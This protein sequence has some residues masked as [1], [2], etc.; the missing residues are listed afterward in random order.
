MIINCLVVD[1]EKLSRDYLSEL[2]R[3]VPY[4]NL[5]A[6][7]E[8]PNDVYLALKKHDIKLVFADIQMPEL[9]GTQLLKS[10]TDPP[11]FIYVTGSTSFAVESYEL[12]ALDYL[13]KPFSFERFLKSADKALDKLMLREGK[14]NP[15]NFITVKDR[16][17]T[18]IL[19]FMEV[20]YV[21][22]AK[23]YIVIYTKEKKYMKWGTMKSIEAELIG[24]QFIRIHRSY[25]INLDY[26]DSMDGTSV[27]LN[28]VEADLPIGLSY[29]ED[30]NKRLY[31]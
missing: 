10:L 3:R 13:V 7:L 22:G 16:H 14:T 25:I 2:I 28:F 11:M 26:M 24:R 12:D 27:R 17:R 21:E 1:D 9:S 18:I 5:V 8:N 23:D 19:P 29:K 15:K 30:L 4:L 20:L 31:L 6:S